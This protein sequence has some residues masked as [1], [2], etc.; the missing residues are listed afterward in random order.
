MI[1]MSIEGL[2]LKEKSDYQIESDKA[3]REFAKKIGNDY[4]CYF[5]LL[6]ESDGG[7]YELVKKVDI[8]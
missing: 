4:H 8:K 5:A 1:F 3:F 6:P 2:T 7:A